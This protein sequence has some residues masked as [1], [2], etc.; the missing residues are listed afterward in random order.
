MDVTLNL[1]PA[2]V[3]L[4]EEAVASAV[5]AHFASRLAA[6]DVSLWGDRAQSEARIRLGWIHD[7]S[8]F[9]P[10]C[11][12]I[13]ELRSSL[14]HRGLTRVIVCGMGGSSLGPDV[15]ARR[16][17][18]PLTVVDSTHPDVL[19]PLLSGELSDAIIVISSKSGTT[20]E[21]DSHL[22]VFTQTL[23]EQ[24]LNPADHLVIVTDPDSA[25]HTY[26]TE[27]DLTVF[28]GEADIGGRYSVLSPFG[29]VPA[30]LAGVDIKRVIREAAGVWTEIF[31]DTL[32]NPALVL[33]AAI[34]VT[35]STAPTLFVNDSG[36]SPGFSS[37]VEQLV[38]ESSGKEGRGILPVVESTLK[39][40][41]GGV[42]VGSDGSSQVSVH[43]S[44]GEMLALWQV[45]TAFACYLL[46]VNPFD[47]PNVESAKAAAR[48]FL[49]RPGS[50]HIPGHSIEGGQYWT[51]GWWD[52]GSVS[53]RDLVETLTS[54][55]SGSD[56]LAV[57][58]YGSNNEAWEELRV[59]LERR[60]QRPVTLGMGPRFLH[61]TGQLHK[62]GPAHGAF[63][64]LLEKPHLELPIPGRDFDF[65]ELVR[66]QAYGDRD[67]L[68]ASGRPVL[69]LELDRSALLKLARELA[70][71]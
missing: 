44:L 2:S 50:E 14:A 25:L 26:A 65:G 1:S 60:L 10:L 56:Y 69:A 21:T 13:A 70:E 31:A 9:L 11:D 28:L 62:G 66:A 5:Q 4:I 16:E 40:L 24:G 37:W 35:E 34:S 52:G 41:P 17:G 8:R 27:H 47:Q 46:D 63:L 23:R 45:A 19:A 12:D 48:S 7:P 54:H 42:F 15:L 58:V 64:S 53:A 49:T 68:I 51:S 67:V 6:A 39:N 3:K 43:G 61:S 38:A 29:L 30:G 18:A 55:V 36:Y 57:M 22:R 20:I 59:G 32:A 71:T 33:G